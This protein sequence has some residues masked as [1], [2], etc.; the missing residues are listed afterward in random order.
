MI[1][2]SVSKS[3]TGSALQR[4]QSSQPTPASASAHSINGVNKPSLKSPTLHIT[5]HPTSAQ[6]KRNGAWSSTLKSLKAKNLVR[7]YAK[8]VYTSYRLMSGGLT[9]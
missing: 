3:L 2:T 1:D 7:F 4:S 9:S 5:P 6:L 8:R